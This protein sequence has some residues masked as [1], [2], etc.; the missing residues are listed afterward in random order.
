M[1]A[2][3]FLLLVADVFWLLVDQ[4]GPDDC[5]P[6]K[7]PLKPDGMRYGYCQ[8]LWGQRFYAHRAAFFLANGR[9]PGPGMVVMHRCDNPQ[10]VNPAHLAEGTHRDNSRDCVAKGRNTLGDRNGMKRIEARRKVAGELNSMAKLTSEQVIEV[11]RMRKDGDPILVIAKKFSVS[12]SLICLIV[13]G[14]RHQDV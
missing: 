5:W 13:N 9:W 10:C 2:D 4:R 6:W 8:T 7:G 3:A 12:K 11:R 14:K 1:T